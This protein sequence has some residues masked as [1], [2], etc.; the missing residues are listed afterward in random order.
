MEEHILQNMLPTLGLSGAKG[1]VGQVS[2][3][4]REWADVV[5][6]DLYFKYIAKNKAWEL[7]QK[8]AGITALR[9]IWESGK[10]VPG[11]ERKTGFKLHVSRVGKK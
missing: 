1:N 7:V 2:K 3:E 10:I 8:R 5:D 4:P 6:W 9:E 11:V